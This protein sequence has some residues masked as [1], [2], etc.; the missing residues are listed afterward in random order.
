MVHCLQGDEGNAL[1]CAGT[2]TGVLSRTDGCRSTSWPE[3]Y[4][5]ISNHT[6]WLRS[7]SGSSAIYPPGVFAILGLISLAQMFF[8][9]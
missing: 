6:A 9:M 7:V 1:V 2:F 4:T 8:T 3:V 5:R